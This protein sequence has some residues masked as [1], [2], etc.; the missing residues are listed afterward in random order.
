[1][2]LTSNIS[3]NI[4]YVSLY[5]IGAFT[6]NYME[7]KNGKRDNSLEFR[8]SKRIG[9]EI[10]AFEKG[11]YH[12]ISSETSTASTLGD[13]YIHFETVLMKVNDQWVALMEYQKIKATEEEWESLE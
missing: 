6:I 10:T 5:A 2:S 1:M 11:I 4:L 9:N 12:Y 13:S 8:F 3:S 7:V